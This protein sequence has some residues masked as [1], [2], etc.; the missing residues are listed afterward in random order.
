MGGSS[1]SAC[2][3]HDDFPE[4][5]N[6]EAPA[7]GVADERLLSLQRTLEKNYTSLVRRLAGVLRSQDRA[8][9]AVHDAYVKLGNGPRVGDVR[10]PLAYVYR[11]ALNLGLNVAVRDARVSIASPDLI[12]SLR[13]EAP[14]PERIAFAMHDYNRL[15]RALDA[16][17]ERRREIFLARW[18]DEFTL[19]EIAAHFRLH[20][21]TVRKELEKAER[22]L[23]G[24]SSNSPE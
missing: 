1:P 11:M 2:G 4:P 21:R 7:V 9:D 20:K 3:P 17:P 15:L 19:D 13:D 14:D 6:P 23:H 16:L 22:I 8:R 24:S 12:S 5:G 18:R 10:N